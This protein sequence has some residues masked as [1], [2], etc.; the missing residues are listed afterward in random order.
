MMNFD[1]RLAAASHAVQVAYYQLLQ[2]G[3][4][5]GLDTLHLAEQKP[6]ELTPDR[7]HASDTDAPMWSD[8][9]VVQIMFDAAQIDAVTDRPLGTWELMRLEQRDAIRK[10]LIKA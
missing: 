10:A 8:Q 3:A 4:H 6:A 7:V 1:A 5:A 2:D 9:E